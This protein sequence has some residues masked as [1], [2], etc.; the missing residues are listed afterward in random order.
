MYYCFIFI[1]VWLLVIY[2]NMTDFCI[3]L[4][5]LHSFLHCSSRW[6]L[7]FF[8]S[9]SQLSPQMRG[10]PGSGSSGLNLHER[11]KKRRKEGRKEA[12]ERGREEGREGGGKEEK[13][14]LNL[15]AEERKL[16]SYAYENGSRC[17]WEKRENKGYHHSLTLFLERLGIWWHQMLLKVGCFWGWSWKSL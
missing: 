2:W 16:Q 13:Y 15:A 9:D 12:R 6:N 10:L 17:M 3:N 8:I 14:I 11:K 5:F 4:T 1:F 7:I